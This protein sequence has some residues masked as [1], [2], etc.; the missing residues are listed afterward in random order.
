MLKMTVF[1]FYFFQT[2]CENNTK[3]SFSGVTQSFGPNVVFVNANGTSSMPIQVQQLL[4][5]AQQQVKQLVPRYEFDLGVVLI[6]WLTEQWIENSAQTY[7]VS[8]LKTPLY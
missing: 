6:S 3:F 2:G 8:N 7:L 5:Q 4:Q 1:N